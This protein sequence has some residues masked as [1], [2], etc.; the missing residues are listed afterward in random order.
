MKTKIT[1]LA[2]LSLALVILTTPITACK[3]KADTSDSTTTQT[4]TEATTTTEAPTEPVTE[5]TTQIS[6]ETADEDILSALFDPNNP[7][8][9][10]PFTGLQNMD[11]ENVG[12]R[13]CGIVVSNSPEANPS[14]GI[15]AA[16]VIYEY[17]VED[18]TRMLCMFADI[19]SMPQIGSL[20]SGRVCAADLCCGTNSF[21]I[22]W[23]YDKTRVPGHV[24]ANGINWMDLNN[25]DAGK[26]YSDNGD[27][28]VTVNSKNCFGWRDKTWNSSRHAPHDA[29]SDGEHCKAGL[30]YLGFEMNGVTPLLFHFVPYGEAPMEGAIPCTDLTVYFT[31]SNPDAHFVYNETDSCYYKSQRHDKAQIDETTGEQIHFENVIVLYVD[32]RNRND[33]AGHKDFY[34]ELG[35]GG[36]YITNGQLISILWQK[37]TPQD[38]IK[39]YTPD[40]EELKVNAGKSYVCLVDIDDLDKTYWS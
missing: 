6:Y 31:Q 28:T 12:K 14:R 32:I 9:I 20:R 15:G 16:D 33:G 39:L 25:Y 1:K 38:Q 3:K 2:V 23:G 8:E 21:F 34:F 24:S 29:V 17:E 22:S 30:E 11:P 40:G 5:P 13:S 7:M 19:S 26:N 10:N 27:G 37:P 35:G 4:S 36:F 18:V